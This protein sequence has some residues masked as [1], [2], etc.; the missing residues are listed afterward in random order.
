LSYTREIA[1]A[2]GGNRPNHSGWPCY[3]RKTPGAS[4][5]HGASHKPRIPECCRGP[6][7]LA[8]AFGGAS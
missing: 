3:R 7:A 6:T 5:P 4:I 1:A 8:A 2:I